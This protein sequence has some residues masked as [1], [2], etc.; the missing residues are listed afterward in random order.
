MEETAT[1]LLFGAG[2]A[3]IARDEE[4]F[5]RLAITRGLKENYEDKDPSLDKRKRKGTPTAEQS[6]FV[7]GGVDVR[8]MA[9]VQLYTLLAIKCN[10]GSLDPRLEVGVSPDA[11]WVERAAVQW[12]KG[13]EQYVTRNR[14]DPDAKFDMD[15][16]GAKLHFTRF[17]SRMS[18]RERFRK[19]E[20][21]RRGRDSSGN[22][23]N[24]SGSPA[25]GRGILT[26]GSDDDE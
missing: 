2:D 4:C 7:V 25:A 10:R 17:W 16:D 8:R 26:S 12:W 21:R 19:Q 24:S 15:L 9:T 18:G 20:F 3:R 6:K 22:N 5:L 13:T 14:I 11:I 23:T 1:I